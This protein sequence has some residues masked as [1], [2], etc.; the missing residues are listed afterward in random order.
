MLK[1]YPDKPFDRL[2]DDIAS[3]DDGEHVCQKKC[4]G[5]RFEVIKTLDGDIH[6]Y[7]R[8]D[9][10]LTDDIEYHLKQEMKATTEMMPNGSQLDGEWMSRR[11][12]SKR[13]GASP[14][15]TLFDV[16]RWDRRWLLRVPYEQ[17]WER[18]QNIVVPTD[19]VRLVDCAEPGE[20][21]AFY[22]KQKKIPTSEGIVVKHLQST[23]VGDRKASKKNPRWFKVR[24]RGGQDGETL[25]DHLRG[26]SV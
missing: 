23:L 15:L 10:S 8:H 6:Y 18:L 14:G 16:I 7:S 20:F 11:A 13:P 1:H 19:N 24:Y 5:W 22:E 2:P 21:V 17:R 9:K 25:L 12:C 4:D 26:G 3:W